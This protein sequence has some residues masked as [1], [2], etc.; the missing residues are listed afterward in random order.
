MTSATSWA[1]TGSS[2]SHVV[3]TKGYQG[4]VPH[5]D[6]RLTDCGRAACRTCRDKMRQALK[7]LPR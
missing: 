6:Y 5:T 4:K 7:K 1:S 2:T 3:V